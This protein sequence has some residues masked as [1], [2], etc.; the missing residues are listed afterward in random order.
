MAVA[1]IDYIDLIVAF[2]GSLVDVS[3]WLASLVQSVDVGKCVL[4]HFV[5]RYRY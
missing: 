1:T 3:Q 5:D 2:C 4:V